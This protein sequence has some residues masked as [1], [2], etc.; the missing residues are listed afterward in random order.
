MTASERISKFLSERAKV[1]GLDQEQIAGLHVGDEREAILTASDLQAV[2]SEIARL[3]DQLAAAQARE[4]TLRE[5][6]LSAQDGSC[7]CSVQD[8]RL[9]TH[10]EY[11]GARIL[12][13]AFDLPYNDSALRERLAAE[14]E[15]CAKL[16]EDNAFACHIESIMYKT[17]MSNAA[18]IRALGGE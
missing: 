17:L 12:S 3:R 7:A 8:S 15:K 14:R 1:R 2:L 11:C 5:A 16:V 6:I 4:A 10:K 9:S 18:A 13:D